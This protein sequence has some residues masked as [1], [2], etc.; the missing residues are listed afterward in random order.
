MRRL[1]FLIAALFLLCC[2]GCTTAPLSDIDG[3]SDYHSFDA[4]IIEVNGSYLLVECISCAENTI[5]QGSQ[6]SLSANR[7]SP[8]N[9]TAVFTAG[10][11][12][13]IYYDGYVMESYPLQL[14]T[15]YAVVST[16]GTVWRNVSE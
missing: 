2:S 12:V 7:L 10:D 3:F 8:D 14:G 6:V 4:R 5:S 1:P 13:R 11:V 15:V 9:D 16:D